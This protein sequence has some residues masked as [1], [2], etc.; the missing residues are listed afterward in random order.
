MINPFIKNVCSFKILHLLVQ[1]QR[2]KGFLNS[3]ITFSQNHIL[4]M[5]LRKEKML[6]V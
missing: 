5:V 6:L 4:L 3:K 2:S 1:I